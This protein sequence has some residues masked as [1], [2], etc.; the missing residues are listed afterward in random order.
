MKIV[1]KYSER[2]SRVS[3][4]MLHQLIKNGGQLRSGPVNSMG[5][6]RLALDL[7]EAREEIRRLSE[8]EK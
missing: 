6:L 7:A 5:V 4:A 8:N 1:A 3:E 2:R